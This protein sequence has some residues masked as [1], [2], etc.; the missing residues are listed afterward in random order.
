MAAPLPLFHPHFR[1]LHAMPATPSQSTVHTSLSQPLSAASYG[2]LR[3]SEHGGFNLWQ[4]PEKTVSAVGFRNNEILSLAKRM[5]VAKVKLIDG[6]EKTM[7][8]VMVR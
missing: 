3:L 6:G 5:R 8:T 7:R 2:I 1:S 4:S